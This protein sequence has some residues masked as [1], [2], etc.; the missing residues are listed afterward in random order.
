MTLEWRKVGLGLAVVIGL[1]YITSIDGSFHFDDSHS[2]E[3]NVAVRSL[4]NIPSFWTDTRTSSFIPENRV[5]RPLVY[6]FYAF[7]WQI[8]GGATWPFHLMKI[9]MHILV[10]LALFMI[11]RRLWSQEGW[12][13]VKSLKLKLPLVSRSISIT[14]DTAAVVLAVLFGIHPT[15]SECVDYISATTSLQC[16]M[17]YLWAFYSYLVFRDTGDRKCLFTSLLLYFLSVA[18]KEEGIT[19]PAMVVVTELFLSPGGAAARVRSAFFKLLPYL[20]LGGLL[21]L[22]VVYMR[23][24]E[25]DESRGVVSPLHYFI[26]QWR[27]YLWYMRLWFWPWDLNADSASIVFSQSFTDPLV[28]RAMIGNGIVIAFAILN[29][30]RFPAMLFGMLWFYITIS[31]A[32]S[33]VV[34]A[35]AINEHRMYLAYIGFVGGTFTVLL[36]LAEQMFVAETRDRRLGW[37]LTMIC[38]GLVAGTQE[39]NR[40]WANDENLWKDTVDKNPTSGRA[41]NNLALVYLSRGEYAKAIE[42]LEACERYWSTYMYCPLNHGISLFALGKYAEAEQS[43]QKAYTFNPR[44]THV[45]FH[46]GRY[47]EEVKK[48][49]EKASSYYQTA[50]DVTGGRYPAADIRLASCKSQLKKFDEARAALNR[51]LSVEPDNTMA[52]FELAKL[53]LAVGNTQGSLTASESLL[54]IDPRNLLGWYNYG[55]ALLQKQDYVTAKTAFQRTIE[56]DPKSEQ[57]WYN[58]A[59][60]NDHLRD[61]KGALVAARQLAIIN[62]GN[63]D[64]KNRLQQLEKKF[65]AQN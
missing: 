62:P 61:G 28:I 31:P 52:Y 15:G 29:R 12:F 1:C 41:L 60:V 6:T 32:S 56:L 5:Y 19:L 21:A 26:T 20:L 34:L 64:Y 50:V 36:W 11:W 43:L 27:A 63:R 44:S 49:Y 46:L 24:V 37:I 59:F 14:P 30:R 3:S 40:V 58:L 55:V 8:G 53:E 35:E 65:G 9:F 39:R 54:R 42:Q 33:V 48:D 38:I 25:G 7:C 47:Y 10:A 23:P 2:V 45:N 17:F 22:W 16:A 57:G 51:A 18:S 13:P 4:T